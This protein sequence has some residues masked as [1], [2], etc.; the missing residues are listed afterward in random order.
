MVLVSNATAIYIGQDTDVDTFDSGD[1]I[2][3]WYVFAGDDDGEAVGTVYTFRTGDTRKRAFDL[4]IKMA[5][6]RRLEIVQD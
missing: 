3:V 6:P 2:T 1:E 5:R 4:A